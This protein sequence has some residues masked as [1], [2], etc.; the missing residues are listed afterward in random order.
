MKPAINRSSSAGPAFT[1]IEL[2]VVIAIIAILAALLL[3]ALAAA[4][5]KA[6][7]IQCLNN[8]KQLTL[9]WVMYTGDNADRLAQNWS[10]YG[11]T[12]SDGSWVT[13]SVR[14]PSAVDGITNGTLY[15]YQ[16][17]PAIYACP[18]LKPDGGGQLLERSV[19]MAERMGGNTPAEAVQ[20]GVYD[21]SGLLGA[22]YPLFQKSSQI[23]NPAP[24]SALVLIDESGNSVDDGICAVTLT[25]WQN[26]PSY[27]HRGAVFSF[28]DGHV[29]RWRWYGI[30]QEL[31]QNIT[32]TGSAQISDFQRLLNAQI[33][34]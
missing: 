26:S 17:S 34:Q 18:D 27:R 8:F 15:P 32:P 33:G 6:R 5:E 16:K 10:N 2:L 11:G 23:A 1:L 13:G 7:T 12:S 21:M 29:E 25:A 9:A 22:A 4:K 28:A 20:Y 30:N 24:S 14:F 19:S 3:P 31:G